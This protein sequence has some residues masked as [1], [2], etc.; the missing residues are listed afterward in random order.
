[1]TYREITEPYRDTSASMLRFSLGASAQPALAT[2][3][4]GEVNVR[5]LGAS[6]QIEVAG[7]T[8]TLASELPGGEPVPDR[9]TVDCYTFRHEVARYESGSGATFSRAVQALVE[10]LG[11]DPSSIIATFPGSPDAVTAVQVESGLLESAL[12]DTAA[13]AYRWR[14]W[15]CYPNTGEIVSTESEFAPCATKE[16]T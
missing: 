4:F 6:H 1:M 11:A 10:R 12:G 3:R 16:L 9:V 13:D 7:M 5:V 8:E 15:H 2:A 14:T